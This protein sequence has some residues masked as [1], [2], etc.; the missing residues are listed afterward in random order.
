VAERIVAAVG[1]AARIRDHEVV[2]QAS[3][4]IAVGRRPDMAP[5]DLLSNA[6][7]A[8][9]RAKR[10]G[11]G[12]VALFDP[13]MRPRALERLTAEGDLRQALTQG[14]LQVHYQ[15][16]ADLRTGEAAGME[17]LARLAGKE[18]GLV[19]AGKFIPLAEETGLILPLG[20]EVLRTACLQASRW[21]MNVGG[22]A[23]L[24]LVNISARQADDPAFPAFVERTLDETGVDPGSLCLEITE[25]TLV[26]DAP[27]TVRSLR[28]VR[29]LGVRLAID[30]FGA[31][32]SSLSYLQR[33]SV[34]V[35]KIDASF[36]EGLGRD[37]SAAALVKAILGMAG[38]LGLLVV[39]EGVEHPRQ[40]D[41]LRDLEC[42]LAQG[43]GLQCPQ[44]AHAAER[45][46]RRLQRSDGLVVSAHREGRP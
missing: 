39:A 38:A 26:S 17:A 4:G 40:L 24:T 36:V 33:F 30:D 13:S 15:V 12:Q 9:Y 35:L 29:D 27:S 43:Y 11:R 19:A 22:S 37:D 1:A 34:D 3:A 2:V 18:H 28:A 14:R 23:P 44:P 8:M 20:A 6:D 46:L 10:R 41:E 31:G 32:H 7:T 25:R 16:V 45:S 42:P 5:E 21:H